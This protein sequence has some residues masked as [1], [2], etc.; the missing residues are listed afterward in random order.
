PGGFHGRARGGRR[1]PGAE[2]GRFGRVELRDGPGGET[3]RRDRRPRRYR[4]RREAESPVD[5]L[6]A[7]ESRGDLAT[8]IDK[9]GVRKSQRG[10]TRAGVEPAGRFPVAFAQHDRSALVPSRP[11][12]SGAN[13]AITAKP[14]SRGEEYRV[15]RR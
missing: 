8:A 1:D 12:P 7:G 4:L 10:T 14:R 6:A 15:R 11:F 9:R 13:L 5:P 3:D 2:R